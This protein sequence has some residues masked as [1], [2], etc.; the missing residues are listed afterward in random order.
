MVLD[1]TVNDME[2]KDKE[3]MFLDLNSVLVK[4][5][6]E[7][8]KPD[9]ELKIELLERMLNWYKK[10]G[11]ITL[12]Q[13]EICKESLHISETCKEKSKSFTYT[14]DVPDNDGFLVFIPMDNQTIRK[15]LK[16][17]K[18]EGVTLTI[19]KYENNKI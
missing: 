10:M 6:R 9:K 13:K 15:V 8:G 5:W 7:Q 2:Q 17:K 4:F 3:K 19:R 11:Y 1:K 12:D 16:L 18:G 14:F